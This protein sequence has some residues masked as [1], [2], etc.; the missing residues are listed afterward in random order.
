LL[1]SVERGAGEIG[2]QAADGNHIGP[3]IRALR[4]QARQASQAFGDAGVGQLA[5][6]F[7]RDRL[8]DVVGVLLGLQRTL[9]TAA[10]AGD[11]HRAEVIYGTL[12]RLLLGL[13]AG[14]GF[15]RGALL[16][17]RVLCLRL[18]LLSRDRIGTQ[19]GQQGHRAGHG[20]RA[21]LPTNETSCLPLR[22]AT[23]QHGVDLPDKKA[24]R[25]G[26]ATHS[27]GRAHT[28]VWPTPVSVTKNWRRE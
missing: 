22:Y 10:D 24:P 14:L 6:V 27:L 20:Q 7:G 18:R 1:P 4:G 21:M 8:D 26:Q 9:D 25:A 3:T 2:R 16:R 12:R 23:T 5:D 13:G 19:P 17:G 15:L 28:T 11:H